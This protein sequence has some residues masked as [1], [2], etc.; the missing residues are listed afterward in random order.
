MAA[1]PLA[2]PKREKVTAEQAEVVLVEVDR[3]VRGVVAVASGGETKGIHF[4]G[5]KA[6]TKGKARF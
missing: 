4:G 1:Q 5:A 2:L 3:W 6:Q